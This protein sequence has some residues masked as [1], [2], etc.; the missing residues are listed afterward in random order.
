MREIGSLFILFKTVF[1]DVL[2]LQIL[3]K[4]FHD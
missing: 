4:G 2:S 1:F 3:G